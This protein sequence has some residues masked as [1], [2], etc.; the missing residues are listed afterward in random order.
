MRIGFLI[1][2][3]VVCGSLD[4][5]AQMQDNTLNRQRA[6]EMKN[7]PV[8]KYSRSLLPV[9]KDQRIARNIM[10]VREVVNFKMGDEKLEKYFEYLEEDKDYNRRM[11]KVFKKLNNN[12]RRDS[13]NQQII[14]I[15]NDAGEKIYN[16]MSN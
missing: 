16:I 6:E 4:A 7:S 1:M 8:V 2:F 15:L 11:D 10:I 12:K 5:A 13:R 3:L 9:N 14:T